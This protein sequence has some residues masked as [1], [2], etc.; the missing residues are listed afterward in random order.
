VLKAGDPLIKQLEAGLTGS[1]AGV[2]IWSSAT[3]DSDWVFR[4]YSAMEATTTKKPSFQFVPIRLDA[5]EL[6]AFA[7]DRVF[8][9]FSA[10]P[11]G[12]NGGELLRLLHAVAGQPLSAEAAHFANIQDEAS[13]LMASQI[14][15][16]IK[17]GRSDRLI[18]LFS[19]DGSPWQTSSAL[20]CKATEGLTKLGCNDEA[21]SDARHA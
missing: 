14:A 13:K 21:N 9:D 6:L 17:Q 16:A 8:L 19:E 5:S 4:E 15:A 11:D 20:G 10:Y 1:Q 12:P 18:Q 7:T 3:A 2:L